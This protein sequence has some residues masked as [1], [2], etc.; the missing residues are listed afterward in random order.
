MPITNRPTVARLRKSPIEAALARFASELSPAR[1]QQFFDR[2]V[3]FVADDLGFEA[4]IV[5]E[6]TP[7]NDLRITAEYP[8]NAVETTVGKACVEVPLI[9]TAGGRIGVIRGF[10]P[11]EQLDPATTDV[12]LR[13]VAHRAAVELE[14]QRAQ[15]ELE[16]RDALFV[17]LNEQAHDVVGVIDDAGA[18]T[19][20]SPAIER[21]LGYRPAECTGLEI[22]TLVHPLDRPAIDALLRISDSHGY[23]VEARIEK[24]GGG[25]LTMAVT[26]AQHEDADGRRFK[27]VSAQDLTDQRRLEDR[28]RQSQ[29]TE[30]I[31]RLASGIV[32]DFG[33]ILMVVGS[34]AGIMRL[35]TQPDDIR[36]ADVDAIE[37]AV[38]R[39][40]DLA[41]QLL[42]FT[43]HREFEIRRI[44]INASIE[45]LA[46]LLR[47]LVGSNIKLDT[48]LA[49]DARYISADAAQ[50]EQVILNLTLNA[51]DAMPNGGQITFTTA[52]AD[53]V[54][55]PPPAFALPE[56]FL[57][58]SVTDTGCGIG[59]DVKP[60]IFEPLFT[61]KEG[62]GTGNGLAI[63]HDIVTRHGGS[64]EV[65]SQEGH[66]ATFRVYL[67][68]H[69]A[70]ARKVAG[71]A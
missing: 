68:R 24:K 16:Q 12:L 3:E 20:V 38:T 47:R 32:H 23:T 28:L 63:V 1:G 44:D 7:G 49:P 13:I 6:L 50:I 2:L 57:C 5:G 35:R 52:T 46:H 40:A 34:H 48:N 29:K 41:R 59:D 26:L 67:P 11:E 17:G 62:T 14:Q 39:G 64:V 33:N 15:R 31:G 58:L 27:V 69:K 55:L 22:V 21:V 51:R 8:P 71:R 19:A 25:W 30:M 66:G 43:R 54:P 65:S 70:P 37:A 56:D 9:G 53:K 4:A 18:F 42:A 36:H 60:H 10:A 45:Q 61:T